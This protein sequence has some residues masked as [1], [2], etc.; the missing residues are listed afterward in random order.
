MFEFHAVISTDQN[1]ALSARCKITAGY[2]FYK[3]HFEGNELMPAA[4]QLH[5]LEVFIQSQKGWKSSILG[6]RNVKFLQRILPDE[7]IELRLQKLQPSTI[8]F[9]L[10]KMDDSIA[11]KGML[12]VVEETLD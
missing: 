2:A 5:M 10:R 7:W 3:G 11:T 9:E 6:G 8:E 12:A 1:N 4:A